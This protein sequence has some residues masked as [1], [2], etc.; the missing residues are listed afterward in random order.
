MISPILLQS[1]ACLLLF[2]K[3][4]HCCN[5]PDIPIISNAGHEYA[6]GSSIF[7]LINGRNSH[8]LR[9]SS[10][11][12]KVVVKIFHA[13]GSPETDESQDS[14]VDGIPIMAQTAEQ[15]PPENDESVN[16]DTSV[17]AHTSDPCEDRFKPVRSRNG[18][19]YYLCAVIEELG[20]VRYAVATCYCPD[21]FYCKRHN[22]FVDV[23][24][25][26]LA[27]NGTSESLHDIHHKTHLSRS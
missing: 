25:T 4:S 26:C 3:T 11:D 21:G 16:S 7:D 10:G 27:R 23:I 22:Y 20:G 12:E 8:R 9:Y 19:I 24:G 5:P 2:L 1:I 13:K 15:E 18:V 17:M 14:Q 6:H